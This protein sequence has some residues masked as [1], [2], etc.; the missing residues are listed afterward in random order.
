MQ[1]ELGVLNKAQPNEICCGSYLP[2]VLAE[3]I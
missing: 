2:L 1:D 3:N